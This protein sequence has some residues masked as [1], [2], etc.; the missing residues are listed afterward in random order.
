MDTNT[1]FFAYGVYVGSDGEEM[2]RIDDVLSTVK[3]QCPDVRYAA[4]G[5]NQGEAVF[6]VAYRVVVESG[7]YRDAADISPEQLAD[8]NAQLGHAIRVL[9]Y[10]GLKRPAWLCFTELS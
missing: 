10:N 2:D 8:W 9:G 4:G 7:E 3:D 5:S 1:A 6:L